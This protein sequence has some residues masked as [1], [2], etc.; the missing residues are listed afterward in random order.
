MATSPLTTHVLDTSTGRP[1]R[2]VAVRL[3][4]RSGEGFS[5]LARS[6]TNEDGRVPDLLAPGTLEAGGYRLNFAIGAYFAADGRT[7]FYP[8]VT[9]DFEVT[10]PSEHHHVPLLVSPFGYSTYR[11]S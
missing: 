7:S 9:I 5:E 11:G 10:R 4:R 1:A 2:G 8:E 6:A 3:E